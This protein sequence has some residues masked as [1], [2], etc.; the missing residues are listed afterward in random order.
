[1][2]KAFEDAVSREMT[3]E[4]VQELA[5]KYGPDLSPETMKKMAALEEKI[6]SSEKLQ[7]WLLL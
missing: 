7:T 2:K 1:M 6:R 5:Q 3:E 4:N